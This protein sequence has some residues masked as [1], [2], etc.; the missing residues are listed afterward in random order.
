MQKKDERIFRALYKRRSL[1]DRGV[2]VPYVVVRKQDMLRTVSERDYSTFARRVE[3]REVTN[4]TN[5]RECCFERSCCSPDCWPLRWPRQR[6]LRSQPRLRRRHPRLSH[7]PLCSPPPRC[8][9]LHCH[10]PSSPAS[11]RRFSTPTTRR[12][13]RLVTRLLPPTF[14]KAT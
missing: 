6:R 4:A 11:A 9:P 5:F 2:I 10:H 12:P 13:S 7:R 8:R 14:T 1:A 3:V